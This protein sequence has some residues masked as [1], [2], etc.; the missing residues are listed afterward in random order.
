M[1]AACALLA[2]SVVVAWPVGA[3]PRHAPD[4]II[5]KYR[6]GTSVAAKAA[7]RERLA[8]TQGRSLDIIGGEVLRV[9]SGGVED[10]LARAAQ[11]PSVEYAERDYEVRALLDPNDTLFPQLWAMRNTG[12]TT[13]TPGAD[14]RATNAWDVF[15]G[16]ADLKVGVI[17]TGVDYRHSDLVANM[18][19]NSG[20]IP[21]NRIDDDQNGYVDDVHGYDFYDNDGDPMDEHF[22]G[23]HCAGTI[24]GVGDNGTGVTGVCWRS[25]IVALRF[26]GPEGAG[27][28]SDA[29][30]CLQYA[31]TV[32]VAVT[33]NSWGGGP[34]TQSLF[35][36]IAAAGNASQLF[37]AAAGNDRSNNDVSPTYPASYD[38]PNILVVA[39]TDHNDE[40]A[41]FSNFGR[42]SVDLGAPGVSIL[43]CGLGGGYRSL[44]GTSMATPHVAGVAA[45][46]YG[47]TPNLAPTFVKSLILDHVDPIPALDGRCVTGGR[48]NAFLALADPDSLAPGAIVD[49]AV[50]DL[51]STALALRWTAAGDD[52]PSGGRASI[53]EARMSTAPID[54]G[55]FDGATPIAAPIPQPSGALETVEVG[56][57]HHDTTYFFA[58]RAKDEWGNVGPIASTMATTLGAPA[59]TVSPPTLVAALLSGDAETQSLRISNAGEGRLDFA[60]VAPDLQLPAKVALGPVARAVVL[61]KG[62]RDPRAGTPVVQDRGG[63]DAFG[64]RWID[65]DDPG[66]PTF[67][68]IDLASGLGTPIPFDGDDQNLGP[69]ALGFDFPFYGGAYRSLRVSTNGWLSFSSHSTSYANQ[70][71]PVAGTGA[72]ANLVAPFWDDLTFASGG[73]RAWYHGDDSRFVV[74]FAGVPRFTNDGS[75]PAV[76]TFE[77]ILYRSG[78]IR[79]Q[80]LDVAAPTNSCTIGI[81]DATRTSG[82]HVAFNTEYVRAGLAVRIDA[83]RRWPSVQPLGGRVFA[84]TEQALDVR[85]DATGLRT[86]TY[87]GALRFATNDPN[88]AVFEVPILLQV[89]GAPSLRTGGVDALDLGTVQTGS[90]AQAEIRLENTGTADL[91][92][93]AIRSSDPDLSAAPGRA[94]VLPGLAQVVTVQWTPSQGAILDALLV[95]DSNDPR[96]PATEIR[97]AGRAAAPPRLVVTPPSLVVQLGPESETTQMLRLENAAIANGADLEFS[98]R[99]D[100]GKAVAG[101][102]A[103]AVVQLGKNVPDPRPGTRGG[104]G[105]DA[106]GY[107]FQDTDAAD[108]PPFEWVDVD[109][110]AA[111]RIP[112]DADD[113]NLG[114]FP[115]G[116]DFPFYGEVQRSVRV[117]TNGWLSFTSAL[118]S[119]S[120]QP[121]PSR[122]AAIPPNLV[123]PFWTDLDFRP[124]AGHGR[125]YYATDGDRFIVSWIDAP[126]H[127]TGASGGA[128]TFQAILHRSGKIV[129]QY[130]DVAEPHAQASIGIQD[131][132]ADVG[133]QVAF[134]AVYAHDA[135]G[136]RIV[137]IPA[138]LDATP[139]SGSILPAAAANVAVTFQSADLEP[140]E[141]A[142]RLRIACND[143]AAAVTEIPVT[144]RVV[145]P[146]GLPAPPEFAFAAARNPAHGDAGF[147]ISVPYATTAD[148]RVHDARGQ[149]VRRLWSGSLSPGVHPLAWDRKDGGGHRVAAGVYFVRLRAGPATKA[150]RVVV[151]R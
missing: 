52:G 46:I 60:A 112:F 25:K 130:L 68:W 75:P 72:P 42:T 13:G 137:R 51:G 134:N 125:A 91:E 41:S 133:L 22:H 69:Y 126:R 26:L 99:G 38:L 81:Q 14:I 135:L 103:V 53:Y 36:A 94:T 55:N 109:A 92:V 80:Y 34:P 47:R 24:A 148:V 2:A 140:G 142:G 101:A 32:G 151:L 84:G 82:L 132:D 16:N 86:G 29:I 96:R 7:L 5:V 144:L 63:P 67:E 76:Y 95:I 114:P 70:P 127:M 48:L 124:G 145:T 108:G 122:G 117:C 33:S 19:T 139:P 1:V 104:G 43:S 8:A 87:A 11:D 15:T 17:D 6:A 35:D 58:I 54:A 97:V 59:I 149:E 23:T 107:R 30:G 40:L 4:R 85:L 98:I 116:F 79:F 106:F 3:A 146:A 65:N 89:T 83:V 18:W 102:P 37:V 9:A 123:A 90:Q 138:W 56:G 93:T 136:V 105:P 147:M 27:N 20:E 45:L 128:S 120:N 143:P 10:A 62:E 21:G 50:E 64:Y 100:Y 71:L 39:A 57:L 141:Y 113:Q 73:G 119:F 44:S 110:L 115:I 111:T 66:G 118:T 61:G 49:F 150:L 28:A 131:A 78:E 88:R 129:F 74:E 77:V 121:L 12:Q 31:I